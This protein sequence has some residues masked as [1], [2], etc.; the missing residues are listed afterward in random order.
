MA[1]G[2]NSNKPFICIYVLEFDVFFKAKLTAIEY[3]SSF[4]SLSL[5]LSL[6]F[7]YLSST[8]LSILSRSF[9]V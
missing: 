5:S 9:F 2:K 8:F 7:F 4:H 3:I 6:S 1:Y